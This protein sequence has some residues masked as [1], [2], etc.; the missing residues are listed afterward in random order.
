TLV[1]GP[2]TDEPFYLAW[3]PDG[4]SIAGVVFQAGNEL[5]Q[6][7]EFDA[8]NGKSSKLAGFKDYAPSYLSWMPSGDGMLLAA[9]ARGT[10]FIRQQIGYF[11]TADSSIRFVTQDTNNY[12]DLRL[13]AEGKTLSA[14]QS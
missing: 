3:T 13:S 6:I 4:K 10:G 9:E 14:I 5:S 11:S 12:K 1:A 7:L 8:V 2:M